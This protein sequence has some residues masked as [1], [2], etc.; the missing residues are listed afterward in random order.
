LVTVFDTSLV[1][2]IVDD[3]DGLFVV[4]EETLDEELIDNDLTGVLVTEGNI[5]EDSCEVLL[6][7]G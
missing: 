6:Y 5:V 3:P 1:E 2:L 7:V 4:V